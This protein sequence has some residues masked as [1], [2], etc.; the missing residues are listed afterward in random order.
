LYI[1]PSVQLVGSRIE[2]TNSNSNKMFDADIIVTNIDNFS[3]TFKNDVMDSSSL[4]FCR[5]D[6]MS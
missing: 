6:I 4:V 5:I 1:N 2:K 3:S